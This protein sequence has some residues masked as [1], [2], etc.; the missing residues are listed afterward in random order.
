MLLYHH[1]VVYSLLKVNNGV[2]EK[3]F[4]EPGKNEKSED[5]DPYEVSSAAHMLDYLMAPETVK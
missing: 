1:C 4:I 5:E 2:I 3:M